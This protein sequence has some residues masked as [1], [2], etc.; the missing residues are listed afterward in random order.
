MAPKRGGEMR[1]LFAS[2]FLVL[3]GSTILAG[4]VPRKPAKPQRPPT[5]TSVYLVTFRGDVPASQRPAVIQGH[6][7][8]LRKNYGALNIAS[9]EVPDAAVMARLRN[10]PRIV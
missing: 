2:V 7:A 6:G 10:D 4:Q 9:V 8:R 5:E 3:I 1:T